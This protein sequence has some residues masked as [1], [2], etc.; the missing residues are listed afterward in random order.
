[1]YL[2]SLLTT[3]S[4]SQHRRLGKRIVFLLTPCP[5]YDTPLTSL[6]S[7]K[8]HV[9]QV[10]KVN[11]RLLYLAALSCEQLGIKIVINSCNRKTNQLQ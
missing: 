2:N 4:V 5:N 7:L 1:M 9:E 11:N 6:Y 8:K 10:A 3:I